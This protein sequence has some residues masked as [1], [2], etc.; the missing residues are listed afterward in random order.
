M[1]Q[2]ESENAPKKVSVAGL[3][4]SVLGAAFG[5]QSSGRHREDISHGR[6]GPYIAAGIVF[7]ALFVLGVALVVRAVLAGT[8]H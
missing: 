5:V 7:T 3:V 4:K 2:R 1:E 8:G 6:A